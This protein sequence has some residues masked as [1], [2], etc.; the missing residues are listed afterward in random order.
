METRFNRRADV[1][2]GT[3]GADGTLIE[4]LSFSD[5][6]LTAE[7]LRGDIHRTGEDPMLFIISPQ[8]FALSPTGL[9]LGTE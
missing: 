6:E 7:H 4:E 3:N 9:I 2:P 8:P 5:L 1:Y